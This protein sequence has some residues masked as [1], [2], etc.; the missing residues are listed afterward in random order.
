MPWLL[1][2]VYLYFIITV[3]TNLLPSEHTDRVDIEE[4][5]SLVCSLGQWLH[6]HTVHAQAQGINDP[7]L[8]PSVAFPLLQVCMLVI[9]DRLV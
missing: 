3:L 8:G 7:F 5:C 2:G 6:I 1:P 4:T 9:V